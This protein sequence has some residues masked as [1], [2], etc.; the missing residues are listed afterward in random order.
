MA[1]TPSPTPSPTGAPSFNTIET[2]G[3]YGQVLIEYALTGDPSDYSTQFRADLQSRIASATGVGLG[4]VTITFSAGSTIVLTVIKATFLT[5]VTEIA[6]GIE[7]AGIS[8]AATLEAFIFS[9]TG[10]TV[11]VV[12]GSFELEVVVV[13]SGDDDESS[14]GLSGGAIAG[15]IIGGVVGAALLGFVVWRVLGKTSAA[16]KAYNDFSTKTSQHV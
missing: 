11:T 8:D 4:D 6:S 2:V 7:D 1:P 14:S 3:D 15:I 10:E 9:A 16:G 13:E 12:P 5:S